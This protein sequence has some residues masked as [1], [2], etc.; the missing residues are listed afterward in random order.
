MHLSRNIVKVH[1]LSWCLR[2][3][4][5]ISIDHHCSYIIVDVGILWVGESRTPTS[6][7]VRWSVYCAGLAVCGVRCTLYSTAPLL[8][9]AANNLGPEKPPTCHLEPARTWHLDTAYSPIMPPTSDGV[10]TWCHHWHWHTVRE[11]VTTIGGCANW[12]HHH[13]H[14]SQQCVGVGEQML[15]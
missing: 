15:S 3:F 4:V 13:T 2:Q 14:Y 11:V 10:K 5:D 9:A 7:L 1:I 8:P 12:R 6:R